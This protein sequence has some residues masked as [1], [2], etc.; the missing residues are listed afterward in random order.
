MTQSN[1]H[2]AASLQCIQLFC[3][4]SVNFFSPSG[5]S[6]ELLIEQM[7]PSCL[8]T[9]LHSFAVQ[10][11]NSFRLSTKHGQAESTKDCQL[12]QHSQYTQIIISRQDHSQPTCSIKLPGTQCSYQM[13]PPQIYS[14]KQKLQ[15]WRLAIFV[16]LPH[17]LTQPCHWT[18]LGSTLI[19]KT[20]HFGQY[21]TLAVLSE[22]FCQF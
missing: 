10:Y 20:L 4:T 2:E 18:E 1:V 6:M 14:S 22:K 11:H 3:C 5:H 21:S 16:N 12:N 15:A 9:D 19:S 17:P 8:N 7:L 13:H